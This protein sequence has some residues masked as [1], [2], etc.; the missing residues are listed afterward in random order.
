MT[1]IVAVEASGVEYAEDG[2]RVLGGVSFMAFK[3]EVTALLGHPE[4]AALLGLMAGV[5]VPSAGAVRVFGLDPY[6]ERKGVAGRIGYLPPDVSLPAELSPRILAGL[7]GAARGLGQRESVERVRNILRRL[8][9]DGVMERGVG[10]LKAED[11]YIVAVALTMIHDPELLLLTN[12]LRMLGLLARLS[13]SSILQ[14]Y[15]QRERAVVLTADS[16]EEAGFANRLIVLKDGKI[17]AAGPLE[18]LSRTIGAENY[19]VLQAMNAQLTLDYLSKISQVKRFSVSRDGS[20][21]VWLRDF[22]S[23][24]PVVLDLLL[25][26]G[27]GVKLL[28]VR[29]VETRVA[30][31]NYL[32][33]RRVSG[34]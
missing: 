24:L 30:L 13:L 33:G 1:G 29:R 2:V 17:A 3:G 32:K 21:R 4:G 28:D 16:V 11:R 20:I 27:L 15:A 34:R 22:E 10:S 31:L 14:E 25:S 18:E 5:R 7:V 19:L 12:P 8:D 9:K 23:D 26:L 6:I